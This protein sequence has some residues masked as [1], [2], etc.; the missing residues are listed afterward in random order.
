MKEFTDECKRKLLTVYFRTSAFTSGGFRW[1]KECGIFANLTD[2]VQLFFEQK[3]DE[4]FLHV[5]G[6]ADNQRVTLIGSMFVS[7][8]DD[9]AGDFK[10]GSV[11]LFVHELHPDG[12]SRVFRVEFWNGE[13][14]DENLRKREVG[15]VCFVRV[16]EV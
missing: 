13:E 8:Q 14:G 1:K 12:N 11:F 10:F 2:A 7:E 6:I 15:S 3:S 4:S 9:V 5:P 16:V